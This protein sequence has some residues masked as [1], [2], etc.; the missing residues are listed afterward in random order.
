MNRD[1][2]RLPEWIEV[3]RVLGAHGVRGEVAVESFSD[4]EARF[5]RGGEL[6]CAG[7]RLAI[8][9]VRR[10]RG[11]LL[12]TLAGVTD[13]DAASALRGRRLEVPRQAV[14]EAPEGEFYF[15]ELEGCRVL[16]RHEGELGT[17]VA[18]REDGGGLLLEVLLGEGAAARRHLPAGERDRPE[19]RLLVPFV[20][21]HLLRVDVAARRVETDLPAGLVKLCVSTS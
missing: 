4:T 19:A 21:A 15:F 3:G 14:P 6:W 2:A 10:H 9:Q 20:K 16:D 8:E 18:V 5:A 7:E 12:L 13:R 11:T 1:E 17:V